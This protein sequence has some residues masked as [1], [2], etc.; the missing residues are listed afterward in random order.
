MQGGGWASDAR[1]CSS[2][3]R[4]VSKP[5]SYENDIGFRLA[6]SGVAD[7]GADDNARVDFVL[8]G[9]SDTSVR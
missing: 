5:Y 9:T 8:K 6:L 2:V 7:G 1:E 3:G 4:N